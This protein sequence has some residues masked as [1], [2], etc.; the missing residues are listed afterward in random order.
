MKVAS[1]LLRSAITPIRLQT[2][3]APLPKLLPLNVPKTQ[4]TQ[5]SKLNALTLLPLR[6]SFKG[7][8]P[9]QIS[10]SEKKSVTQ[11]YRTPNP[12]RKNETSLNNY[13]NQGIF[14]DLSCEQVLRAVHTKFV[15]FVWCS[16]AQP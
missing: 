16:H 6:S 9:L 5:T 14:G 8:T 12:C 1:V 13:P 11:E 3:S 7:I 4:K 15:E 10:Q 2:L